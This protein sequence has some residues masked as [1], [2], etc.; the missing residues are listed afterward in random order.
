M[1]SDKKIKDFEEYSIESEVLY[2]IKYFYLVVG[3]DCE[4]YKEI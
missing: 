4:Y 3:I 2:T 1:I